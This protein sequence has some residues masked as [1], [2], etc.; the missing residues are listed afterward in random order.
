[1]Y[2]YIHIYIYTYIHIYIYTY[3][4]IYM[5]TC[6]HIYIYTYIHIYMYTYIH[7]YMYTCIRS[8]SYII[9]AMAWVQRRGLTLITSLLRQ[10]KKFPFPFLKKLTLGEKKKD[11][12]EFRTIQIIAGHLPFLFVKICHFLRIMAL[13]SVQCCNGLYSTPCLAPSAIG[14][15]LWNSST[16]A[17]YS[18]FCS[19]HFPQW[20]LELVKYFLIRFYCIPLCLIFFCMQS[21]IFYSIFVFY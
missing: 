16:L 12:P 9:V 4:H 1:M 13:S 6:I 8:P 14:G 2:T 20:V 7:I 18:L 19:L 21:Y 10:G 11:L 15:L 5:Y 3:I 17:V